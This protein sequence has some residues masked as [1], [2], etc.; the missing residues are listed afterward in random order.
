MANLLMYSRG[1][2]G[3]RTKSMEGFTQLSPGM[4]SIHTLLRGKTST[5]CFARLSNF[6]RHLTT[7]Q[8]EQVWKT[9]NMAERRNEAL[10]LFFFFFYMPATTKSAEAASVVTAAGS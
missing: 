7:K 1:Q 10:S 3:F 6:P 8:E 2:E 9:I 4:C 5:L